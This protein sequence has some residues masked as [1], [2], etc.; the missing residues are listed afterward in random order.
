MAF[1]VEMSSNSSAQDHTSSEEDYGVN[2]TYFNFKKFKYRKVKFDDIEQPYED[3]ETGRSSI[4][5]EDLFSSR[6]LLK[7]FERKIAG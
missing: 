3:I 7:E 5:S 6:R 2:D 1:N 4:N